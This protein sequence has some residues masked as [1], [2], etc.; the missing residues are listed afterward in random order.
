MAK[1]YVKKVKRKTYKKKPTYR[2]RYRS[3]RKAVN[4]KVTHLPFGQSQMVHHK[5]CDTFNINTNI[6]VRGYYTFSLNSLYDPNVS[7]AGHQPIGMDQVE[8]IFN[9][10]CV[11]GAYMKVR[12]MNLDT[13]E[14][15]MAVLYISE[16]TVPPTDGSAL[17]EQ[18]SQVSMAI[19]PLGTSYDNGKPTTL[20]AKISMKKAFKVKSLLDRDDI[21]AARTAS[22]TRQLYGHIVIFQPAGGST[23]VNVNCIVEL[24]QTA[25]WYKPRN[26]TFST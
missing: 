24:Y 22:P 23:S 16:E 25:V 13:D 14:Y 8:Q 7:A 6:G 4:P 1:K 2:R 18:G 26:L 21:N 3:Y 12:V 17:I 11:V 20:S 19:P 9:N 10:Y 5:Y 15:I